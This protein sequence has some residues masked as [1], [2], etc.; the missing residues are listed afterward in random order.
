MKKA[1][2]LL[3]LAAILVCSPVAFAVPVECSGVTTVGL[4]EGSNPDGCFDEDK[5]YDLWASDLA[6]STQLTID[7]E[8]I[9][10]QDFHTVSIGQVVDVQGAIYTLQYHIYIDPTISDYAF[11]NIV[12]A[13]LDVDVTPGNQVSVLKEYWSDDFDGTLV[14]SLT[15]TG[16]PVGDAFGGV[17]ELYVRDTIT[18]VGD[19][20]LNSATNGFVQEVQAGVPEPGTFVLLGIGLVLLGVFGRRRVAHSA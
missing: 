15:S 2:L 8:T 20:Q 4:A 17:K 3:F 13:T 10:S 7:N 1:T 11:R 5:L 16:A 6:D 14:G 12:E 9:G 19:A 18:Y